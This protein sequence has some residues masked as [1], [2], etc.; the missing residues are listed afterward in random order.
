TA[1]SCARTSISSPSTPSSRSPTSI[2][3]G[4]PRTRRSDRRRSLASGV[5]AGR[6]ADRVGRGLAEVAQHGDARPPFV[7]CRDEVPGCVLRVGLVEH[8]LGGVHVSRPLLPIA[9]IVRSDLPLLELARLSLVKAR[10]LLLL[11]DVEK[12]LRDRHAVV[13]ERLLELV[14]LV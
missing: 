9:P 2:A 8:F 1:S 12:E 10:E 7:L 13:D 3:S 14:D 6:S 11:R 4:A 5:G